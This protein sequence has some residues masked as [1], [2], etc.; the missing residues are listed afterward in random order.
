[1]EPGE[2]KI[3]R[4]LNDFYTYENKNTIV[5][6]HASTHARVF[7]FQCQGD[8]HIYTRILHADEIQFITIVLLLIHTVHNYYTV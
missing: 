3:N 6:I 1:M 5:R 2:R 4:F 7:P 8:I